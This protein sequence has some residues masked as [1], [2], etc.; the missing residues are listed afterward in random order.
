MELLLSLAGGLRSR[1]TAAGGGALLP[2]AVGHEEKHPV[3]FLHSH[4]TTNLAARPVLPLLE[5]PL[6]SI[7]KATALS[8]ISVSFIQYYSFNV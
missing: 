2:M 7:P 4:S 8:L 1:G 6:P 3:Q 5:S